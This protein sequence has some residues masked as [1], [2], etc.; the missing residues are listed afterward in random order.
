[1]KGEETK[2]EITQ[3]TIRKMDDG[4]YTVRASC[5]DF[6]GKDNSYETAHEDAGDAMKMVKDHMMSP[7]LPKTKK[8][9]DLAKEM[10]RGKVSYGKKPKDFGALSVRK[11]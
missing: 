7:H 8:A 3:I 5:D 11:R 1:M 6:S 9:T 2:K 10:M 4:G